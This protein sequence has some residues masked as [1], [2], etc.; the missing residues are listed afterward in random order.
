MTSMPQAMT[1]IVPVSIDPRCAS[2]SMPRARPETTTASRRPSSCARPRAK[3]H[4]AAEALRAP[5]I[6]TQGRAASA[7]SPRTISAGG[8]PS[9]WSSKAG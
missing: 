4:A 3:R 2:V 6:A 5:T 9:I 8:A 7:P 1:P